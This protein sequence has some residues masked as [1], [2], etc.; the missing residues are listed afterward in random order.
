M[1]TFSL[2]I[3]PSQFGQ[4]D[5]AVK[6][7]IC[8]L[9]GT[10]SEKYG[11]ITG[12]EN[13]KWNSPPYPIS[14]TSGGA[15]LTITANIQ[16]LKPQIGDIFQ[17]VVIRALP[18]SILCQHAQLRILIPPEKSIRDGQTVK[19]VIREIQFVNQEYRYTGRLA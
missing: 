9:I 17:C 3:E 7:F 8:S 18:V 12:I 16:R 10:C 5:Q 15:Q 11:H 2:E 13:V 19:V 14:R 6:T 1:E 4:I